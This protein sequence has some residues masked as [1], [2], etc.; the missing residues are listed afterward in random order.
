MNEMPC[1]SYAHPPTPPCRGAGGET[2]F[3]HVLLVFGFSLHGRRGEHLAV[4]LRW[5]C[6]VQ[7]TQWT[8][9]QRLRW[10]TARLPG[11]DKLVPRFGV[12]AAQHI[13]E[14]V[15]IQR[16]PGKDGYFFF[17]HFARVGGR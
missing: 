1:P 10:E 12:V 16:E 9:M 14:Q 6:A 3:G 15:L 11:C 4:F 17:N 5:Y 13:L 8:D 2:W 7:R